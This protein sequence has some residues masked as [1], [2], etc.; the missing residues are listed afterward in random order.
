MDGWE[1]G[2]DFILDDAGARWTTST[3][4]GRT[5][6]AWTRLGRREGSSWTVRGV[7]IGT[8]HVYDRS[9]LKRWEHDGVPRRMQVFDRVYEVFSARGHQLV[10]ALRY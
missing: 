5:S 8:K 3:G 9:A 6:R 1:L 10:V 4:L 7:E 2:L